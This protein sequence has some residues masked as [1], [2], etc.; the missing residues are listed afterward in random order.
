MGIIT[1]YSVKCHVWFYRHPVVELLIY[2]RFAENVKF[3]EGVHHLAFIGYVN[4]LHDMYC[5]A[6][7]VP[8][9]YQ[10]S[11]ET[12]FTASVFQISK[13]LM[14]TDFEISSGFLCL[15]DRASSW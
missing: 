13:V 3:F 12:G 15:L 11:G 8:I 1:L 6:D 10:M 14:E 5:W 7:G 4:W 9:L 2:F